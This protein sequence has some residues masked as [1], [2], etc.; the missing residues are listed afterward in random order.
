M[1]RSSFVD[2]WNMFDLDFVMT[3]VVCGEIV[4]SPHSFKSLRT[5]LT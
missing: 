5:F 1:V 4:S 3:V 2:W